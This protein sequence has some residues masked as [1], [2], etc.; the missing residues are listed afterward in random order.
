MQRPLITFTLGFVVAS[1]GALPASAWAQEAAPTES[2]RQA[3]AMPLVQQAQFLLSFY[4][5]D[6]ARTVL[7]KALAVQPDQPEA[8]FLLG[9]LALREGNNRTAATM[10]ERLEVGQP[11]SPFATD[12]RALWRLHTEERQRLVQLRSLRAEGNVAQASQLAQS[13]FPDRLPPGSLLPEFVDLLATSPAQRAAVIQA[14][15]RRLAYSSSPRD[16]LAYY[17]LQSQSEATLT[18]SL[19]GFA[20][21][22]REHSVPPDQFAGPWRRALDWAKRGGGGAEALRLA[23]ADEALYRQSIPQDVRFAVVPYPVTTEAPKAVPRAAVSVDLQPGFDALGQNRLADAE[24]LFASTLRREPTRG[25]ASG[26]LGIVRLRQGKLPEALALFE[27]AAEH[28]QNG[29]SKADWQALATMARYKIKF[30]R[31]RELARDGRLEEADQQF[32]AALPL[33]EDP[34][35]ALLALAD[36]RARRG[37][38]VAADELYARLLKLDPADAYV[39]RARFANG[40][41]H[42]EIGPSA[43]T[44]L[45]TIETEARQHNLPVADLFDADALREVAAQEVAAGH[46]TIAQRLLERGVAIEGSAAWLRH[47]LAR[48]YLQTGQVKKALALMDSGVAKSPGDPQMR[49]AA[50]LIAVAADRFDLALAHLDAVPEDERLPD[51]AALR[52]AVSFEQSLRQYRRALSAGDKPAA[53]AAV[54]QAAND[55]LGRPDRQLRLVQAEVDV[56][57]IDSARRHL[58]ALAS[59]TLTLPQQIQIAQ[60]RSMAGQEADAD[61]ALA[62]LPARV[63]STPDINLLLQVQEAVVARRIDKMLR[64]GRPTADAI[65]LVDHALPGWPSGDARIQQRRMLAQS[66]LYVQAKAPSNA[67]ATLQAM[68]ALTPSDEAYGSWQRARVQVLNATGQREEARQTLRQLHAIEAERGP[69]ALADASADDPR[70][71]DAALAND[72]GEPDW[73]RDWLAPVLAEREHDPGVQL[74]AARSALAS[75]HYNR[76]ADHLNKAETT[77][78]VAVPPSPGVAA[79]SRSILDQL[80]TRRQP[81]FE[82]GAM[83]VHDGGRAG[84][85]AVRAREVPLRLTWPIGYEGHGFLQADAVTV[86]AGTLPASF[87]AA[88]DLGTVRS[89]GADLP[90]PVTQRQQGANL[91]L[92]WQEERQRFDLGL[93]GLGMPVRNWVGGWQRTFGDE[94][95]RYGVDLSR[96]IETHRLLPYVG[97]IDPVTGLPWG[98]VT[99]TGGM[100][101]L[102]QA[103][104]PTDRIQA[105]AKASSYNGKHVQ[106][107]S[108]VQLRTAWGRDLVRSEPLNL[109]LGVGAMLWR[110][111]RNSNFYSWGHGGY[112]SPQRYFSLGVPLE[113]SG[114]KD[115]WSYLLRA[116]V[117]Y[118]WTHEA[119]A[120]YYPLDPTLLPGSSY[121][122]S[123]GHGLGGSLRAAVE[124]RIGTQWDLGAW[125]DIDRSENYS[126]TRGMLYLRYHFKPQGDT[127]P[128][129][130]QPLQPISQF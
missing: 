44:W 93:V 4:R 25:A 76:A 29:K 74:E 21:L 67:L 110:F 70:L 95:T 104:N 54:Q 128:A 89:T 52:S 22:A 53:Q 11:G 33:T 75:G 125:I 50:A 37:Q 119:A 57:L 121:G 43:T 27:K 112:Y 105:Y 66:R 38:A 45:D 100:V 99:R 84:I 71:L 3:A 77:A 130:P 117:T 26:G 1:L 102:S 68:Q 114:R 14:L 34:T 96:R 109:N 5:V 20:K 87:A 86:D 12:L 78:T 48:R 92:G 115:R 49:H 69:R 58:D 113:L 59:T 85:S 56:G 42:P 62:A 107:N 9:D 80:E 83:F 120:P 122:S 60:L 24:S 111:Q 64:D 73:A 10:L 32:E 47:D 79:A 124:R 7:Q 40:L 36:V 123:N 97:A 61:R 108:A 16:R 88:A 91:A 46:T 98:G 30:A 31:G 81:R 126:P 17:G 35:E 90:A 23:N 2:G 106:S 94:N 103:L 28:E 51:H 127:A 82:A 6:L 101:W 129:V 15:P 39:W 19:R 18:E 65:D 41:R 8:L 72:I 116:S 13:L 118:A 55:T 63:R